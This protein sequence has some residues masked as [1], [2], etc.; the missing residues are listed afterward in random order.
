MVIQDKILHLEHSLQKVV[1]AVH[2]LSHPIHKTE[3]QAVLVAVV[4]EKE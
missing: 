2:L 1:V 3:I 4:L